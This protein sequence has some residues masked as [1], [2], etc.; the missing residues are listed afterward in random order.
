MLS[1]SFI[2]KFKFFAILFVLEF[3]IFS[4]SI[5]FIFKF[6]LSAIVILPDFSDMNDIVCLCFWIYICYYFFL[7][8]LILLIYFLNFIIKVLIKIFMLN[9]KLLNLYSNIFALANYFTI[10]LIT[11]FVSLLYTITISTAFI[12]YKNLI[13]K[14]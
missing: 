10:S 13:L 2:P 3:F 14:T 9:T 12:K 5:L 6:Q 7:I 8:V 4:I 1:N 11:H